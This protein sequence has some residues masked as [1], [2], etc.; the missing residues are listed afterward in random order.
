[1][2]PADLGRRL[3]EGDR[4]AAP[5]ALNLIE[6]RSSGARERAAQLLSEVSPP[7]AARRRRTWLG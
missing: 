7:R 4:S 2:E 6:D 5:A 3:R 1:M